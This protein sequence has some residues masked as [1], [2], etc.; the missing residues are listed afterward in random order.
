MTFRVGQK[1]VCVD[2]KPH[3]GCAFL[4]DRPVEGEIYTVRKTG[5]TS[6]IDGRPGILVAE[7]RNLHDACFWAD[8]FRP[9]VEKKT[10]ISIF[11]AMLAPS[12]K[13][14]LIALVPAGDADV[15]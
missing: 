6:W 7:I 3:K 2:N 9:V 13:R 4:G 1:V 14:K 5:L 10:D 12:P 15:S 11:E 8:R